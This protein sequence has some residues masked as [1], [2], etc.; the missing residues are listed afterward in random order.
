MRTAPATYPRLNIYLDDAEL[1]TELKIAAA[2][3]GVSLSAYCLEA[4]RARLA[5][6]ES[7]A[8][9]Q[10]APTSPMAAA[11]AFDRLRRRIGPIGIPVSELVREGRRR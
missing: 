10:K 1:R 9:A 4:I 8:T 11:R 6:D 2:R 7:G 3:A 5:G